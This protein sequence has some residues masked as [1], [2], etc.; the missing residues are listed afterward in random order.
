[1]IHLIRKCPDC[2][3]VI[4]VTLEGQLITHIEGARRY[5]ISNHGRPSYASWKTVI[6]QTPKVRHPYEGSFSI[7]VCGRA[8][9]LSAFKNITA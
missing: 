8:M 5:M 6:C 9:L 2:K 1:M 4:K 3:A 7:Y